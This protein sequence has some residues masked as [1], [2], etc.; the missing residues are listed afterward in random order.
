MQKRTFGYFVATLVLFVSPAFAA[1]NFYNVDQRSGWS[2]CSE[3]A[4]AGG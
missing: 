4:G 2:A 3:C 1:R